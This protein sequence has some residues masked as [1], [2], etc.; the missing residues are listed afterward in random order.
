MYRAFSPRLL[1][2]HQPQAFG[3]GWYVTRFQRFFRFRLN[4]LDHHSGVFWRRMRYRLH[5]RRA[6]LAAVAL[7]FA[8]G[9]MKLLSEQKHGH[10]GSWWHMLLPYMLMSGP[11]LILLQYVYGYVD[12]TPSAL[13]YRV[14]W[15][16]RSIP[17]GQIERID[18]ASIAL[19]RSG[20]GT[21]QIFARGMKRLDLKLEKTAE[22]IAELR[23]YA[24]RAAMDGPDFAVL[25]GA[26]V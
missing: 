19:D 9:V 21:T 22:F 3:L 18:R 17:Y 16:H 1:S 20:G 7:P 23:Q 26:D 25:E 13:E 5:I 10:G 14:L 24:P 11:V 15:Q 12:L 4:K 8:D 2:P 6:E